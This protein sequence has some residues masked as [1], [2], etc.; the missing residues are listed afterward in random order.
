MITK[1]YFI[2]YN[3]CNFNYNYKLL[4]RRVVTLTTCNPHRRAKWSFNVCDWIFFG[5]T[6]DLINIFDIPLINEKVEY[7][8]EN[9]FSVINPISPEQYIWTKF[10]S[11]YVS[12]TL[13]AKD[14]ISNNNIELSEKYFANNCIFLNARQAGVVWQKNPGT[15]YAQIPA[16]SS[17]GLYTFN[18]YKHLLNKYANN[19]I[20]II[21]NIPEVLLYTLLYN[22]R[23]F[24]KKLLKKLRLIK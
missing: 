1:N 17:S 13:N 21:P 23:F 5:L 11:K 8:F 18:E 4:N 2:K 22:S 14:D 10:L 9:G 3:E 6:E 20:F 7:E 15:A 16:L 24:I 19:N 12:I